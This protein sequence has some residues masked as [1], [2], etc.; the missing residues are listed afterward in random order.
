MSRRIVPAVQ[1]Q[2]KDIILGD[3]SGSKQHRDEVFSKNTVLVNGRVSL[4]VD[5]PTSKRH[6]RVLYSPETPILVERPER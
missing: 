2:P 5:R 3:A 1:L 6:V 4:L